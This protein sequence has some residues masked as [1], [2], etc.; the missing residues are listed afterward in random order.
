MLRVTD[1]A[2]E[3]IRAFTYIMCKSCTSCEGLSA[4]GS[5]VF[6]RQAAYILKVFIQRLFPAVICFVGNQ[7]QFCFTPFDF[8]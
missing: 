1:I 3:T 2:L 5:S 6:C 8:L 4:N 7:S